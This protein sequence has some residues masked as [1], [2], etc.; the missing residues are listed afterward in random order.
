MKSANTKVGNDHYWTNLITYVQNP[1]E[2][3]IKHQHMHFSLNT[4]LV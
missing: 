1:L 2:K 4:V 3:W